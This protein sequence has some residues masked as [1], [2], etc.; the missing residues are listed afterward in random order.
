MTSY[1]N[2]FM[3]GCYILSNTSGAHGTPRAFKIIW[4]AVVFYAPDPTP[5]PTARKGRP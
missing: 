5:W 1:W 3:A 4:L 2:W